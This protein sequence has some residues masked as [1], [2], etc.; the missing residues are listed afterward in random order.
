MTVNE[1]NRPSGSRQTDGSAGS[2]APVGL[3]GSFTEG[4]SCGGA[5]APGAAASLPADA[6]PPGAMNLSSLSDPS[7][8]QLRGWGRQPSVAHSSV[9]TMSRLS[10]DL[11]LSCVGPCTPSTWLSRLPGCDP[12]QEGQRGL[13]ARQPAGA[14]LA[15]AAALLHHQRLAARPVLL[16]MCACLG[17]RRGLLV[18]VFPSLLRLCDWRR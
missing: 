5:A 18:H 3:A 8:G 9:I 13:R 10:A 15:L 17:G 6:A 11:A 4:A 16:Q 14:G 12:G 2:P 1:R 7:G